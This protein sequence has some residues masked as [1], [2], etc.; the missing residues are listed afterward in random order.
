MYVEGWPQRPKAGVARTGPCCVK[1]PGRRCVTVPAVNSPEWI[2]VL[3]SALSLI[4]ASTSIIW[5]RRSTRATQDSAKS[6]EDSAGSS[7]RSAR[8]AEDSA[9]SS[10]RSAAAA[11]GALLIQREQHHIEHGPVSPAEIITKIVAGS[12]GRSLVGSL[13][14]ARDYRIRAEVITAGQ[15][16]RDV[17]AA[18]V[19]RANQPYEMHLEHMPADR[20]VPHAE[21]VR[22]RFWPPADVDRDAGVD[23][24]GCPCGKATDEAGAPDGHWTFTVPIKNPPPRARVVVMR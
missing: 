4:V 11:E 5:V 10:R 22:F 23:T 2:S 9:E 3:I 7:R 20:D 24:W 16:S 21:A 1:T 12:P 14:V 19:V 6:A 8:A 15:A 18:L 17:T 13:T